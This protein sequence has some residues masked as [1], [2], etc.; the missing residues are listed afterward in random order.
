MS[1]DKSK[2]ILS[3][4]ERLEK[5]YGKGIVMRLGDKPKIAIDSFPT[6][7]LMLDASLGIGG[8]PRGRVIEVYGPEASGKTTIALHAIAEM[9]KMGGQCAFVDAEHALDPI[10]ARR[11]G[12]DLTNFYVSQP[13]DG[14]QALEVVDQLILSSGIDLIVIDSVAALVPRA[15]IDGNMGDPQV[16]LQA[17]LMSQAM[18]KIT[19][20][21]SKTSTTIIFINQLRSKVGVIFGNPETTTGGNAL[22]FY[23]TVRLEVRRSEQIKRGEENI[24]CKVKI[25]VV[26][27]KVAPPFRVAET[28]LIYGKGIS[29]LHEIIDLG[30]KFDILKK[31]G[32]WY[33]YNDERLA[34]GVENLRN[35]LAG[36]KKLA[37]ELEA[38]VREKVKEANEIIL[39]DDK[40]STEESKKTTEPNKK[41]PS[42][43]ASKQKEKKTEIDKLDEAS[44]KMML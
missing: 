3:T 42:S 38:K 12:I 25:K 31:A 24:G 9:Q 39:G 27:N 2:V 14:E 18:R 32:S 11:I 40:K 43:L 44:K 21:L 36:D 5:Q 26:K 19:G 13:N 41:A 16:A 20:S 17:R 6:G 22:K 10:Y 15:E 4:I 28:T 34:Q 35:I 8:F 37:D 1:T 7:S 30:V 29:K 23:S 33:S